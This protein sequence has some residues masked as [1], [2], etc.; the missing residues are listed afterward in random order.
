MPSHTVK[1]KVAHA[2]DVGNVDVEFEVRKGNG[3][4]GRV[5]VSKGGI[6]WIPSNARNARKATWQEFA[7]WMMTD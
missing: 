4:L 6:D 5:K 7:D 3:L 2:V 1:L